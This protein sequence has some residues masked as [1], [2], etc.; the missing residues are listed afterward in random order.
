MHIHCDAV[1]HVSLH[2]Y[3]DNRTNDTPNALALTDSCDRSI[4]TV[5]STINL[6][7][8]DTR[9]NH[10]V[11]ISFDE[12]NVWSHSTA[13]DKAILESAEGWPHAPRLPED[14]CSF[15]DVLQVGLILNTFI[16]KSTM[17]KIACAARPDGRELRSLLFRLDLPAR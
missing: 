8:A 1:D 13:Q 12:W 15:E 4:S 2:L 10:D 7:K 14:I 6:V 11:T 5:E 16:R 9:S 3:F 17:V